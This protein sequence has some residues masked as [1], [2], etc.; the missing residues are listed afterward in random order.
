MASERSRTAS[1]VGKKGWPLGPRR[2]ERRTRSSWSDARRPPPAA[3]EARAIPSM[4]SGAAI[5]AIRSAS[6]CSS[7][8]PARRPRVPKA[9]GYTRTEASVEHEEQA[10]R[11]EREADRLEEHTEAVGDRI[12][13]VKGDWKA[14]ES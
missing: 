10:E 6:M 5:A 3:A 2:R 7:R 14:K 11:L 1:S 12:E 13:D 8:L 4:I 9:N